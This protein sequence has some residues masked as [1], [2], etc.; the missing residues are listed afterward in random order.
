MIKGIAKNGKIFGII[1]VV[2]AGVSFIIPIFGIFSACFLGTILVALSLK[3]GAILGYV[4]GV[5]NVINVAFASP[6]LMISSM[7]GN[8]SLYYFYV[9]CAAAGPVLL[10]IF[11]K[12]ANKK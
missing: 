6:S 7:D 5:L 11:N 8:E 10:F 1:A 3:D 4:A 2:V 12:L 9:G